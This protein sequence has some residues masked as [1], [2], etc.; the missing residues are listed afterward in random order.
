M[1]GG[2]RKR[3]LSFAARE[4]DIVSISNV[5]FAERNPDGRTPTEEAAHR[6]EIVRSAAGARLADIDVE[7]SPYFTAVTDDT[8]AAL[9]T[10]SRA[11]TIDVSVLTGHP[12][13]LVGDVSAIIDTL[14]Q[15]RTE[16]GINYVTVQQSQLAEFAP[17]VSALANT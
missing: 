10:I 11:T 5:A 1:I 12:N 6:S 13:V 14:Q 2:A 15:R 3:V 9:D 16:L 4:A 8:T 7:S 17:V